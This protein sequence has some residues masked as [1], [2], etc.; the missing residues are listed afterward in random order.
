[1]MRTALAPPSV[2]VTPTVAGWAVPHGLV[3]DAAEAAFH[4]GAALMSLDNLA[5][6]T[7]SWAGAW[8]QRLAL[9]GAASAVRLTG[10]TEDRAALRDAWYLC[11]P[12]DDL[13]PAGRILAAWR[14]LAD[15]SPTMDAAAVHSVA[16]LLG[17]GGREG[18][19]FVPGPIADLLNS[20]RPAPFIAAAVMACVHAARPD[21]DLLAWWMADQAIALRMRWAFPLPLLV[22]QAQS[23]LFRGAGRGG[24]LRPGDAAFQRALCL[25]LAQAAADAC[26]LAGELAPRAARLEAA[27]PKLRAKGAGEAV[28]RL[29]QDDAVPGTL[30]TEQLSRWGTR[31]LFERLSALDAVREL[32]GRQAFRLYGL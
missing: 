7:P 14:R 27:A 4:A 31:R 28:R 18:L 10:R 5:R 11:Q 23:N 26:R 20:G 24:R 19:A 1:M 15:R 30:Q 16:T 13:G 3:S 9:A 12:G 32:T 29:L 2:S 22:S 17:I 8:R 6:S 25:A 21:A